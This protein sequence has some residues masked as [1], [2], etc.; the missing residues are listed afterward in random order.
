MIDPITGALIVGGLGLTGNLISSG[1]D[2]REKGMDRDFN[3]EE[4]EKNRAF[5]EE[6]WDKEAAYN[7]AE[8]G[9]GRD[10]S[11]DMWQKER[12]VNI[13][14]AQKAR[15]FSERMSSTAYQ[16]ATADLKKAGINPMLA[17]MQGGASTPSS[18]AASVG[19]GSSSN[20]SVGGVSGSSAHSPGGRIGE[21]ISRIGSTA[22]EAM[23]LAKEV[24]QAKSN[25]RVNDAI[26]D[27]KKAEALLSKTNADKVSA[28]IPGIRAESEYKEKLRSFE[29]KPGILEGSVLL[30]KLSGPLVSG[31][32]GYLLRGKSR[33]ENINRGYMMQKHLRRN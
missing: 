31:A 11:Y 17:Y 13:N 16:R 30:D 23:V 6:M 10:F 18:S 24:E 4:A 33:D 5:Q 26:E 32:M 7:H 12:D 19:G 1:L 25:I 15:D 29:G 20:A 22:M 14:E 2:A 27:A 8:A 21:G 28:E 9:L 3:R